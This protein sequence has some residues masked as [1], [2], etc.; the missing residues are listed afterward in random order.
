MNYY[1]NAGKLL[2]S[3]V[4]DIEEANECFPLFL[5]LKESLRQQHTESTVDFLGENTTN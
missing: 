2:H 4:I 1:Q 5:F 3:R